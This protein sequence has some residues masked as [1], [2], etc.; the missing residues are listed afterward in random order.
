MHRGR[1]QRDPELGQLGDQH[2]RTE[3]HVPRRR[4][5]T[6]SSTCRSV[7]FGHRTGRDD[8][9]TQTRIAGLEPPGVPLR[10]GLPRDASLGGDVTDRAAG[11]DPLAQPPTTLRGQW[12]IT[13]G[14]EGLLGELGVF[15][16]SL[17]TS[18][19]GPPPTQPPT[20]SVTNLPGYNT[21]SAGPRM[22]CNEV[23]PNHQPYPSSVASI[24]GRKR[25]PKCR[26]LTRSLCNCSAGLRSSNPGSMGHSASYASNNSIGQVRGQPHVRQVQ[27]PIRVA[28]GRVDQPA[29]VDHVAEPQVAVRQRRRRP[30]PQH[31]LERARAGMIQP[32]AQRIGD[33]RVGQMT[34]H[35]AVGVERRPVCAPPIVLGEPAGVVVVVPAEPFVGVP[36]QA[37]D[38]PAQRGPVRPSR[39]VL[40]GL[41]DELENKHLGT[42]SDDFRCRERLQR[43][44]IRARPLPATRDTGT[45]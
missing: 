18:P 17:H 8:R 13:V 44:A 39:A 36:V 7:W 20:R 42:D 43:A 12:S 11:V 21:Y 35:A 19:G 38:R 1:G 27:F 45:V 15:A 41:A 22:D 23:G 40:G 25:E 37:G 34:E 3:F 5:S 33:L 16:W 6:R 2:D 29:T 24:R 10:Q 31:S 28:D 14:H 26:T 32:A 30:L 9:S 4:Y